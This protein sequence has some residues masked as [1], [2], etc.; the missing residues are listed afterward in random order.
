MK[1]F[2]DQDVYAV[3]ARML[4]LQGHD[5]VTAAEMGL[6][7]ATDTELLDRARDQGR[8]L[9]TR[10]RDFGGFIFVHDLGAGVIYLRMQPSTMAAVH[11]E[12]NRVL[13]IYTPEQ[14]LG[15]FVVIEPARHRFRRLPRG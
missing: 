1:L 9:I 7:R 3:T 2:L 15:A 4:G 10:D 5:V 6:S 12:L 14:L 8:I 13:T 11:Q